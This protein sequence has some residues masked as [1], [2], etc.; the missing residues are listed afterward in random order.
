M[1]V[2]EICKNSLGI[3]QEATTPDLELDGKP[4]L[5]SYQPH[6]VG[7]LKQEWLPISLLR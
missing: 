5:H 3:V 4:V 6:G 7:M 2:P 1:E